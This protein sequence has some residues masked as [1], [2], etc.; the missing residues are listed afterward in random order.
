MST[1]KIETIFGSYFRIKI[2]G[3]KKILDKARDSVFAEMR[4]Y[5]DLFSIFSPNSEVSRLNTLG[6]NKVS[7]D[8][9]ALIRQAEEISRRTD[10][11][12][13]ITIYPLM[14]IWGF[15]DQKYTIPPNS[16]IKKAQQLVDYKK[17]RTA[18]DSV[19]LSP[20]TKIDLG[21][22]AVGYSVDKACEMLKS[23]G[24]KKGLIDA[25]G[26]IRVFGNIDYKIGIKH[27]REN[28][29]MEVVTIKEQAIAT[30]GDYGNYFETGGRRFSHILDPRTG[31]P[32]EGVMSVT[33]IGQ[34]TVI[35]DAL[36]TALF[37]L[38]ERGEAILKR[39]P[40][41]RAIVYLGDGRRLEW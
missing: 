19:Y 40:G 22:I 38:G 37:V 12:F 17:V 36:A 41:Y 39:F 14:K 8:L 5:N 31:Y 6:K 21:G 25:G 1:E 16:E 35:C 13:D 2:T 7:L 15:Y 27:P 29:V 28:K 26:E 18:A 10:G 3:D 20:E 11:A 34:K 32:A 24:I 33:V 4:R 23:L 30:S 9:L